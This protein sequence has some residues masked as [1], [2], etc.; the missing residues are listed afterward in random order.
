MTA[1]NTAVYTNSDDYRAGIG[2][3]SVD[4]VLAG[5]GDFKARLTWLK[6]DHLHAFRCRENI[7]RIAYIS[8][9]P[10]RIF[11]SFPLTSSSATVWNGVELQL[12]DIVLHSRGERGHQWTKGISQWALVSLPACQFADYCKALAELD[13]PDPPVGRILRLPPS[14]AV[15]LRRLHSKACNLAETKPEIFAHQEAARAVEQEFIYMLVNCLAAG[16]APSHPVIRQRHAEVMTGF[17]EM[18][19][20]DFDQLPSISGFCAAVGVPERTLR[21]CCIKF[22]GLCPSQYIRLRRLNLVRAE[23]CRANPATATVAQIALRHQFSELGRFVAAYRALFGERPS[24][25][26]RRAQA[27]FAGIA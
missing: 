15:R 22:L 17:E 13:L 3:A 6:L 27:N 20:S 4:L 8:L 5:P 7:P 10:T 24:E 16:D 25:T 21:A 9:A 1:S 26:L 12:G 19:R 14:A 23:L 18:L 2:D 11:V